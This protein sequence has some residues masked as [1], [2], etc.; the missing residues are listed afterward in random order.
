M[1]TTF[2]KIGSIILWLLVVITIVGLL[3]LLF[4]IVLGVLPVNQ[5]YQPSEKG[6]K[7]YIASNG[8][9]LDIIVP[10]KSELFDWTEY[11]HPGHY[12]VN[13]FSG[14]HLGFGW[15]ERNFYVNTPTWTDLKPGTAI[16]AMCWPTISAMHVSLY[17]FPPAESSKNIA[18]FLNHVEYQLLIDYMVSSFQIKNGKTILIEASGYEEDDNFYEAN[19]SYHLFYTSNSWVNQALKVTGVRTAVWSPFEKAVLYQLGKI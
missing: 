16:K 8:V 12:G 4:S 17:N 1:K 19:G 10:A 6:I 13:H 3:Y 9:H 5:S 18:I 7:V 14:K 15:G 11:L 2:R